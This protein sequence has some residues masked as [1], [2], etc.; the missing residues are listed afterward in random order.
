[1]MPPVSLPLSAGTVSMSNQYACAGVAASIPPVTA[2][3][4]ATRHAAII[5]RIADSVSLEAHHSVRRSPW[6]EWL[7][8][9]TDLADRCCRAALD[10]IRASRHRL[11]RW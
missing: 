6:K 10:L 3:D 4:R 1:M 8:H 11:A 7:R 2:R 5:L 9:E